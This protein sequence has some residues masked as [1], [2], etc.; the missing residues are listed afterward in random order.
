LCALV[1]GL[2][3]VL[4]SAGEADNLVI[5]RK[6]ATN[7]GSS[8]VPRDAAQTIRSLTGIARGADGA[9]LASPE[10]VNQPF[11]RTGDGGRENVLVRGVDP[12]AF[13]VHRRGQQVAGPRLRPHPR[14]ARGRRG[15]A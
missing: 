13:A 11:M 3:H 12:I 14:R 5:M 1:S 15:C 10:L 9:A 6:G 2:K 4:V 7:D 8:A